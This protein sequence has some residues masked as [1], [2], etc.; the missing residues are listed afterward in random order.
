MSDLSTTYLGLT[1]KSPIVVSSNPWTAELDRIQEMVEAGVGAIILPSLFEEQIRLE[2]AG[3]DLDWYRKHPDAPAPDMVRNAPQM[4]KYNQGSGRYIVTIYQAKKQLKGNVPIIAS[5]NG[6]SEGGWTRYAQILEGAGADG[7]EL[8]LYHLPTE[9]YVS[10]AEVE[11]MYVRLVEKIKESVKIPIAVKLNP[12][13][14]SLPHVAKQL[15]NA[16]ADALVLFNRFYEPD[17][18]LESE[19]VEPNLVLSDSSELRLRLRW[20]AILY[21]QVETDLA[22]TGGVHT[23][24]DVI[25]SL[26]S[27]SNVA[28]MASAIL[29]NGTS[30]IHQVLQNMDGWMEK[31]GYQTVNELIGRMSQRSANNPNAFERANY[32]QVLQSYEEDDEEVLPELEE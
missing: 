20:S 16:G 13:F 14:S 18:D 1:L 7:L 24:E 9:T 32:M 21:K 6:S 3:W 22:I 15:V 23:A 8:N 17:F 28:M 29:K 25:K 11:S 19:L 2:E 12:Y 5:L 26:M 30:H 10:G 27:G 31:R 4:D